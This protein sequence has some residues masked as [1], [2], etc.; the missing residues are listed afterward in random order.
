MAI[1]KPPG[2]AAADDRPVLGV[3]LLKEYQKNF[4]DAD[5]F[6]ESADKLYFYKREAACEG[7]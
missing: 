5:C 1:F 3:T 4:L 2:R 7:K 6:Q